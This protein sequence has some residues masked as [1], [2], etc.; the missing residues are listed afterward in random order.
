MRYASVCSGVEAASLAW[1]P[2]GWEAV[3]FS[4]IEPFPCAVLKERFPDV[5]NLGDM[6]KIEGEKYRGAVDLLVG[7]TP[8]FVAGT[9]V[10]TP[11]GYKAIES[12]KIGDSV[13]THTGDVRS[14]TAIGSKEAQ[15]GEV[16]ILGRPS[17][18]CT[19][20]HPFY[21]IE[22][23]RDNK[24]NSS[25]YGQK[26]EY[27]EYEF[28]AVEDSVGRYAGRVTAKRIDGHI[29]NVY[30]ATPEEIVELAGWYVGDGYIRRWNGKNKKAVIIA[31]VCKRKI[32]Q[33]SKTFN[34]AIR[35]SVAK[36]GK[37][38]ITN[39]VLADWLIENFGENSQSKKLPY[40][41]YTSELNNRFIAGYEKTDGSRRANGNVRIST[42]SAAIAYG[43]ADLYGNASV[44]FCKRETPH[45]IMG[46]KVSQRD[47]YTVY[48]AKG[49]TA[50]TKRLCGRYASIIRGWNNDGAIRTVYNITVDGEHSYIVNG[51]AVHNCQ[52]F[53]VAGKQEGLND[54]RSAL[55]LAYCR[56]L[57]TMRP[58]W[59][60]WENVP[61]VFSTNQGEDF[62]AFL[63]KIDE[64]GYSVAWRVLDAQYVRVDGYPRAVPQRRRRVFVVGHLGADWRY[65]ASVLFEP[66]C[67]PGDT[68]PRRVKG[69]GVARS[70]TASTGGASGKEQQHTF[71]SGDGRPLNAICRAGDMAN[72]ET[73]MEVGTTLLARQY[74]SPPFVCAHETGQGYWQDGDIAGTLRAEGENRPSRP[75]NIICAGFSGGQGAKAGGIGYRE[76]V[77][78]TIRASESGSNQVPDILCQ[79]GD[80]AGA[81]TAR[82]D[83]SPCADRGMSIVYENHA[84]DSRVKPC[85]ECS[86]QINAK[87]GTGGGN[88]PILQEIHRERETT[89]AFRWAASP[90]Q[91]LP[92]GIDYCHTMMANKN[93]EPAVYTNSINTVR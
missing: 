7:G 89:I 50:R 42:T 81:L 49:K 43:M 74:K 60:V 85:G 2:L 38:T 72:S 27:G 58:R 64:I 82:H 21:S 41:I 66:G 37:I 19:G 23:K 63:Q 9:M 16:K 59:F 6:T 61:G 4:E 71:I 69:A 70:L 53:S 14:I 40:W 25:T 26:V 45:V 22:M 24:R 65:P 28:K 77:S 34:G 83:S 87:A 10:L 68:P 18:R 56:L 80:V 57:E 47:T 46:R 79:Y 39:T 62:R 52:G 88:L 73:G 31:A 48:K 15:T 12:L 92:L 44:G 91:G 78:P 1:M 35:Y 75:S 32:D 86:P 54:P 8:C 90:T 84:Q 93:G 76:E 20:N 30:N 5:P 29:P 13:V 36:D 55:C 11:C 67:L 33:F 17:I 3:W 51:I